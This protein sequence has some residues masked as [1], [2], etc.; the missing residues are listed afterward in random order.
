MLDPYKLYI[1]VE[2]DLVYLLLDRSACLLTLLLFYSIVVN[3]KQ[4]ANV[5]LIQLIYDLFRFVKLFMFISYSYYYLTNT[6]L[7][8]FADSGC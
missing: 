3:S 5:S 1:N 2:F 8:L 7:Y 6:Y 4:F